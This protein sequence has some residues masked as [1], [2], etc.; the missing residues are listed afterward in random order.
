MTHDERLETLKGL[1]TELAESLVYQWVKTGVSNLREFKEMCPHI[2]KTTDSGYFL[3]PVTFSE[4]Q[5]GDRFRKITDH[6]SIT[7]MK[8]HCI[9]GETPNCVD[10][11]GSMA[12]CAQFFDS[13]SMVYQLCHK[14]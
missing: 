13:E 14:G 7:R 3:H 6:P 4:L 1:P 10:I 11:E 2:L 8:I 12:G 5:P 9:S